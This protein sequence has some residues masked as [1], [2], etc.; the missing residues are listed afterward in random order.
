M[1]FP[2]QE[3]DERYGRGLGRDWLLGR[4]GKAALSRLLAADVSWSPG[5][6]VAQLQSLQGSLRS[7]RGTSLGSA[8]SG[9]RKWPEASQANG[10]KEV[11]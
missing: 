2:L 5:V 3:V 1:H 6:V 9:L 10:N 11:L 8:Q 4:P 7:Y